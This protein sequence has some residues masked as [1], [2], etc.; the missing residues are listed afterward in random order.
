MSFA[1]VIND[2]ITN[3]ANRLPGTAQRLDNDGWVLALDTADTAT[4]EA[5]GWFEV[6]DTAVRPTDTATTT[7]NRTVELV[8]GVPTVV[9]VAR[10]KSDG[11][12]AGEAVAAAEKSTSDA[13]V[14]AHGNNKDFLALDPPTTAQALQQVDNLT[15]QVNGLIRLVVD[16]GLTD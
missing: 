5:C 7:S 10:N 16:A 6:D 1:R 3:L 2:N 4:Q 14:V 12:L 15:R 11:E 8:G 13:A 9:W